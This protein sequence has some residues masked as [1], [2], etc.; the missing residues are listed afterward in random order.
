MLNYCRAKGTNNKKKKGG[1][2]SSARLGTSAP[3]GPGYR[4]SI[5]LLRE[6]KSTGHAKGAWDPE[7]SARP[8]PP[9]RTA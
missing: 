3:S 6:A 5:W 7:A 2:G 4:C 9:P 1:G 8:T